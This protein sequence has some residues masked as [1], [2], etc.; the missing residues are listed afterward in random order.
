MFRVQSL[1]L[2]TQLKSTLWSLFGAV[3]A[4]IEF[5]IVKMFSLLS[6]GWAR[7]RIYIFRQN[8]AIPHPEG[9]L[10]M[11]VKFIVSLVSTVVPRLFIPTFVYVLYP[12]IM[13]KSL[14]V[15][16]WNRMMWISASIRILII[17]DTPLTFRVDIILERVDTGNTAFLTLLSTWLPDCCYF[18]YGS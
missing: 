4:T 13:T 11:L 17:A 18:Y 8:A 5:H 1:F 2:R 3:T 7:Q 12:L 14:W 10:V 6:I 15:A 16:A 9:N